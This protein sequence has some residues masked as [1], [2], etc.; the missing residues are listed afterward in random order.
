MPEEALVP[1]GE[2]LFSDLFAGTTAAEFGIPAAAGAAAGAEVAGL[3]ADVGAGVGGAVE[4]DLAGAAGAATGLEAA[5]A[6]PVSA[7]APAIDATAAAAAPVSAA[8]PAIDA[9]AAA[10][11]LPSAAGMPVGGADIG[12]A[13]ITTDPWEQAMAT[14]SKQGASMEA[15]TGTAAPETQG[16]GQQLLDKI[17]GNKLTAG[18]VGANV[19]GGLNAQRQGGKLAQTLRQQAQPMS[20]LSQSLLSQYQ[21]GTVPSGTAFDIAQWEQQQISAIKGMAAK[22]GG[23]G[24]NST[25]VNEQIGRVRAQAEAMRSQAS[26]GLLNSAMQAMGMANTAEGNAATAQARADSAFMDAQS[27]A[28]KVL[29]M[30]TAVQ[31]GRSTP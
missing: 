7:A 18:V 21:S 1:V 15:A 24:V 30:I 4:G 11:G 29:A 14:V 28:A 13:P 16:L 3:G 6:A 23:T 31:S 2:A 22:S 25:M 20:N 8:A 27:N 17:T 9:A 10:P 12:A 5:A 19:L 26:Q